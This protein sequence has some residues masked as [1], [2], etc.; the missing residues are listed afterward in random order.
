MRQT[1]HAFRRVPE[2]TRG[3]GSL[4]SM[5]HAACPLTKV[6]AGLPAHRVG[7]GAE[8]LIALGYGSASD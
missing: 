4:A 8:L 3:Q 7:M 6:G 1:Q 2:P 5:F